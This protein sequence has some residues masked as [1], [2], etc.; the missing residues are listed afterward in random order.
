MCFCSPA[1]SIGSNILPWLHLVVVLSTHTTVHTVAMVKYKF[2]SP[3]QKAYMKLLRKREKLS[4]RNIA[5]IVGIFKSS[6]GRIIKETNVPKLEGSIWSGRGKGRPQK[7]TVRQKRIILRE[8]LKL[9][10]SYGNI[11]VP[12]IM[13]AAQLDRIVVSRRTVSRFLNKSGYRYLQA[14]KRVCYLLFHVKLLITLFYQCQSESILS[15]SPKEGD[16]NIKLPEFGKKPQTK[17][18]GAL[19]SCLGTMVNHT[20]YRRFFLL[21]S[22][23][24]DV[25]NMQRCSLF[26]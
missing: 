12:N 14:R 16:S 2:I 11:T 22:F 8:L 15:F 26:R 1:Q 17:E 23:K 7:L 9:R 25:I 18:E 6:V 24:N 4:F 5:E 21:F 3:E 19:V 13:S 20:I 10:K